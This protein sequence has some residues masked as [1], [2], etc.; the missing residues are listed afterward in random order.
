MAD[1][2]QL[3]AWIAATQRTRKRLAYGLVPAAFAALVVM[4][5]S[6]PLGGLLL[7]SVV[8]VGTFGFWIT[9]GHITEWETKIQNPPKPPELNQYGRRRRERD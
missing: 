2:A 8:I 6:R 7:V 1:R 5:W 4:M 9:G 3:E